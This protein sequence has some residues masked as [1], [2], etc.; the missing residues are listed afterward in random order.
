M[1]NTSPVRGGLDAFFRLPVYC[2]VAANLLAAGS[3]QWPHLRG[4]VHDGRFQELDEV[5]I[6]G[7]GEPRILWEQEVGEGFS[8][9]VAAG[10][11]IYTQ[12]QSSQGQHLICLSITTGRVF[13]RK[14]YAFPWELNGH[15]PGPFGTPTVDGERV[16]FTDCFGVI[17]CA[18]VS[19]GSIRWR[20][21]TVKGLGLEGTDFGY[22][23]TPL[24]VGGRLFM[25]APAGGTAPTALALD[26]ATGRLL[27][28]TGTARPSYSSCLP[29]QVRGQQQIV[30][31]HRNGI[32]SLDPKTGNELWK[33]AWST[34]Y[35]EHSSWPLYAEPYLFC[36]SPFRRGAR[37]YRLSRELPEGSTVAELLWQEKA[38]SN[39]I[40]S[41][42]LHEGYVY[43]FDVRS[44]QAQPFGRTRGHFVCLDLSTGKT[45][46]TQDGVGY[47][48]VSSVGSRLLLLEE[49]GDL[50]W[51]SPDP[52]GY[53]EIGRISLPKN[54]K[55]WTAPLVLRDRV[56]VRSSRGIT[57]YGLGEQARVVPT[58]P[59]ADADLEA[60]ASLTTGVDSWLDRYASSSWIA[61]HA[62]LFWEWYLGGLFLLGVS[63]LSTG[64]ARNPARQIRLALLMAAALGV[65]GTIGL[66]WL[67]ERM[68]F[69]VP[70]TLFASFIG[71]LLLNGSD[72]SAKLADRT[73]VS[74]V[75]S[76]VAL[77]V[78]GAVCLLYYALC[79]STTLAAGWGFLTGLPLALPFGLRW[80]R[81][82]FD[83]P[84]SPTL[85]AFGLLTFTAFYWSAAGITYW[86]TH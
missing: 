68:I 82:V 25:P 56:L 32:V 7:V 47:C 53:R 59:R 5:P 37:V 48:S 12:A 31:L 49:E 26:S 50:I 67:F 57:C 22:A 64:F 83:A 38:L 20:F 21:D 74:R 6:P 1:L 79:A 84:R 63:L 16:Y 24:V 69:C 14:R 4:P 52:T 55:R 54:G 8:G 66:T 3:A 75:M 78:F 28:A 40:L 71:L 77:L 11:R 72:R 27:W 2:L 70:L 29:I 42:A 60:P 45:M 13:W 65:V 62:A 73:A 85:L 76:R 15:Y 23:P 33:D 86:S 44:H 46:W 35:N 34:G 39:D 81:L 61:P 19:D 10:N 43:G 9:M 51:V 58:P 36:A 18:D 41:S 80:V 30:L 17:G